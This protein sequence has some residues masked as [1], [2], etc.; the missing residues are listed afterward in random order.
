LDTC[1]SRTLRRADPH[2]STLRELIAALGGELELVARFHDR[3]SATPT[4]FE[5][6]PCEHPAQRL[7]PVSLRG[8]PTSHSGYTM[9]MRTT[10]TIP[11]PVFEEAQRLACRT[12]TSRSRL[13]TDALREYL[14]RHAPDE[15]A[16]TMDRVVEQLDEAGP[17]PFTQ[18]AST[19]VLAR[20]E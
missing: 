10:V 8:G 2:L 1:V 12:R 19:A 3:I 6:R 14:L 13:Y 20:T 7:S 5:C 17:N 15:V 9:G 18:R 16:D 4:A 11:N